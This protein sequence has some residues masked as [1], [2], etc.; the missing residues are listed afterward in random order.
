M[1]S[2]IFIV[3]LMVFFNLPYLVHGYQADT[4]FVGDQ[5]GSD[6]ISDTHSWNLESSTLSCVQSMEVRGSISGSGVDYSNEF[7]SPNRTLIATGG[8]IG[9][10]A[11]NCRIFG[12]HSDI[13]T[14]NTGVNG[15]YEAG[16]ET[17]TTGSSGFVWVESRITCDTGYFTNLIFERGGDIDDKGYLPNSYISLN[18]TAN[19]PLT[20]FVDDFKVCD[21]IN[22]AHV[23]PTPTSSLGC[24][25]NTL[26]T[27]ILAFPFNSS[28]AG[29]IEITANV[30]YK[31]HNN[32]I[33]SGTKIPK[34]ELVKF[35][36]LSTIEII[37]MGLSNC[38]L[39]TPA[40]NIF[41]I[42]K[43]ILGLDPNELYLLVFYASKSFG[44][45]T[46]FVDEFFME[47][48]DL[49]NI[50]IDSRVADFVCGEWSE[51]INQSQIRVCID[52]S[53]HNF[54]NRIEARSC[55]D[56]ED[57]DLLIL[58]FEDIGETIEILECKKNAWTCVSS[59]ETVTIELPLGWNA[60]ILEVNDSGVFKKARI[61]AELTSD[62]AYDGLRSLEINY[63]PPKIDQVI[64]DGG[65]ASP[66]I[67]GNTTEG[68]IP[69]VFTNNMTNTIVSENFT[70]PSVYPALSWAVKI[71]PESRLQYDV[72]FFGANP[73]CDPK[74]L[75][76]GNCNATVQGDYIVSLIE[77]NEFGNATVDT[78]FRFFGTSSDN[79]NIITADLT[80]ANI[81]TGTQYRILIMANPDDQYDIRPYRMFFDTFSIVS[82]SQPITVNCTDTC[83]GRNL[84]KATLVN[85]TCFVEVII[86]DSS[87]IAELEEE[88]DYTDPVPWVENFLNDLGFNDTTIEESGFGFALNFLS[89]MFIGL[90]IVMAIG[91]F[92]EYKVAKVGG[93]GHGILFGIIFLFGTASMTI[94]GIFPIG[95][96]I[97]LLILSGFI[98]V[99]TMLKTFKG[100]Q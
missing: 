21:S 32:S 42:S 94:F 37:N 75:C 7:F 57:Y 16:V 74:T 3:A 47:M 92:A 28:D 59:P 11:F 1:R 30:N 85:N 69:Q 10:D 73:F 86:N 66:A 13:S 60:T 55:A 24:S 61:I 15:M 19:H 49:V 8:E 84:L 91:V 5:A 56:F 34:L 89:P 88:T 77:L 68:D 76:Y 80:D 51:C 40:N 96:G 18:G 52:Q 99:S 90:M 31:C 70:F 54:P 38:S 43:T 9:V 41:N 78:I 33:T 50:S 29:N 98:V 17:I 26:C 36:D 71:S 23:L 44:G 83:D 100:G 65:G 53:I 72:D 63:N 12:G 82:L 25:G 46:G 79:W 64:E 93:S 22:D 87:C 6:I 58:G 62:E 97:M 2:Y 48:P 95:W 35:S 27:E 4:Y 14:T 45:G 67:C 20:S 39:T 81:K